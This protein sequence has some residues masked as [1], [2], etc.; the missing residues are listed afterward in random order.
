MVSVEKYRAKPPITPAKAITT[1]DAKPRSLPP[2]WVDDKGESR[3]CSFQSS[4]LL[5]ALKRNS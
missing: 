1:P 3:G 2:G 4:S 5:Q